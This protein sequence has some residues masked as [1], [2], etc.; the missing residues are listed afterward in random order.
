MNLRLT[1]KLVLA[2]VC[3]CL[4]SGCN[5]QEDIRAFF[6]TTKKVLPT[7]VNHEMNQAEDEKKPSAGE[8]AKA[9]SELLSEMMKVIF[10]EKEVEDKTNFGNLVHS[11]NQGASLEGIYRGILAGSRYRGLEAKSQA[12]SPTILKAFAFEMAELQDTMK[13]PSSFTQEARKAPS[14]DFPEEASNEIPTAA[15]RSQ[16]VTEKKDKKDVMDNLLQIFIGASPYTLKRVLGEEAL[17]KMEEL[18]NSPGELAQWYA[19]STVRLC[20]TK[21]D[22]GLAQRNQPDFDFHFKFAQKMAQDRVQWE[23]L[24]RYHRYLN[25]AMKK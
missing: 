11:L 10:D 25:A 9:N 23:T 17:R 3:L 5:P 14:I 4:V 7:E 20:D 16:D 21:V 24:N 19:Q 22:F 12:A 18:K 2:S 13:N 8:L 6:K 15:P 1:Q